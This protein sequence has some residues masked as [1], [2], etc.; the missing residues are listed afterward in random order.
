[1]R[2]LSPL[3]GDVVVGC[4]DGEA[5][6][7]G[8]GAAARPPAVQPVKDPESLTVGLGLAGESTRT[9]SETRPGAIG[10]DTTGLPFAAVRPGPELFAGG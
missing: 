3:P 7:A 1:M 8:C 6:D 2:S 4:P 5:P 10:G 9:G